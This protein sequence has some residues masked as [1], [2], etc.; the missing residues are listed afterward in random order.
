[1]PQ[2]DQTIAA[3]REAVRLSPDSIP[4]R[5]HL[6][7]LLVQ[8]G[9]YPAAE[10][11]YRQALM[12]APEDINIKLGL[13]EV[14]FIQEKTSAALVIIE[15]LTS[16]EEPAPAAL[17]LLSRLYLRSGD[18]QQAAAAYS[19][20]VKSDPTLFDAELEVRFQPFL[21]AEKAEDEAR[22]LKIPLGGEAPPPSPDTD[23]E[24]PDMS[25]KDVGGMEK[26][27]EE[28][29][30]KIIHPLEHP[31]IYQAYGKKVGG[32]IL[33]YGPPGCGKTYL[34]RATAGEVNANFLAVGLHDVLNMYIGQS[35]N[36]LH[37]LFEMARDNQPCVL[38]FDEVDALGA[39]RSDLRHS[40]GRQ[41]INQ[42]LSEMDGVSAS[43]EGV[44]ILAATNAPWHLDSA[45]RRPG[46]FDRIIFVP[47]PDAEAREGILKIMLKDKPTDDIQYAK[48]AKK[49]ENFSGADLKAIVDIAVENKLEAAMKAGRPSPLE[50]K[51]LMNALK[52]LRP[53]TKEWFSTARN[54]ALYSNQ[55]GI[56]DDILA[57]LKIK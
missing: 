17:M 54:Y 2:Q 19:R 11:E 57:Y 44:L 26:L 5:Q 45:F 1:M 13:A 16:K 35:E 33:M 46:R 55:S 38:F 12:L 29:R 50:T 53:T 9:D 14:F 42:F 25:F 41:L 23:L 24:R 43:N 27:K 18:E 31:E 39:S 22:K 49:T 4:L 10:Q 40:A 30:M 51:D 15:E 37:E 6:A 36:N 7:E 3:I 8:Q 48:I 52:Q 34:A 56:Y 28:I 20:A 32:G 47:P 21:E